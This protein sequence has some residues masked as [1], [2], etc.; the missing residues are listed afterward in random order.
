VPL[1]LF[2]VEA[3]TN[4]FKHAFPQADARGTVSVLLKPSGAGHRLT[5]EDDGVG[6]SNDTIKPGIGDR[7]LKVFARQVHGTASVDSK[8]GSGTV[9]ELEFAEGPA[10]DTSNL[11]GPPTD[12]VPT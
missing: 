8:P 4:V 7:L 2:V 9:V 1:A 12:R 6:F 3:L 5:I 11:R 10:S